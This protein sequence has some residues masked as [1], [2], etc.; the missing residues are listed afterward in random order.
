M[1]KIDMFKN[2]YSVSKTIRFRLIPQGNTL[3]NFEKNY[4]ENDEQRAK[5]YELV[6]EYINRYHQAFIEKVLANLVLDEDDLK[7]YLELSE[8]RN[9]TDDDENRLSAIKTSLRDQIAGSFIAG[10]NREEFDKLFKKELLDELLPNIIDEKEKEVTNHFLRFST[11]FTG[12]NQNRKNIYSNED[13]PSSIAYRCISENLPKFVHNIIAVKKAKEKISNDTLKMV[14]ISDDFNLDSL[15]EIKTFNKVLSQNGIDRYNDV[16]NGYVRD[17]GQKVQGLNEI[18]NLFNQTQERN[19]RVPLLN[20]LYKQILTDSGDVSFIDEFSSDEEVIETLKENKKYISSALIELSD[21]IS[22]FEDYYDELVISTQYIPEIS[23]KLFGEWDYILN[24]YTKK[25]GENS[26]KKST[27]E[28][29]ELAKKE[30]NKPKF[31]SVSYLDSLIN[32]DK[33]ENKIMSLVFNL[34]DETM[35]N[36]N[37]AYIEFDNEFAN[38]TYFSNSDKKIETIKHYLDEVKELERII[39]NI[40]LKHI[41]QLVDSLLYSKLLAVYENISSIDLIYNMVRNYVTRKPYSDKKIKL[42]FDN[43]QL[44]GGWDKNKERDYRS[45]LLR[46]DD[47]YYLAIMDKGNTKCFLSYPN[48]G[49]C[50]EKMEYKLLPGPNK[51]LP[52]VFFAKSNVDYYDPTGKYT[53]VYEKGTF[54]K[55]KDFVDKDLRTI[56]DFY[57]ESINKHGDWSKFNFVFRDTKDYTDIADFYN[58]ISMQGYN[59]SFVKISKDYVDKLVEEGSIYLFQL[60]NKD[61]SKFSKGNPNMH[62]IYFRM[63]FDEDN[64]KD[65]VYKLNGECEMF[66]RKASLKKEKPTHPANVAIKNKN[67]N[68]DKHESKFA[69]DLIKDKRYT[70]N[71][72]FLHMPITMNYKQK[73]TYNSLNSEIKNAIVKSEN[74]YII[75]ID[76]GERNLVYICVIDNEGKIVE[77]ESL[78][79]IVSGNNYSVDYQGLLNEK[80]KERQ[81]ARKDWKTINNIKEIKEG[82]LSQV[83]H[84]ICELVVKYDAI[85]SLENLN[86]GFKNSR[87]KIEKQVYEKF[88]KMLIEK[89]SY[90]VLKNSEKKAS[91]GALRAYQLASN[92]ISTSA[93]Q[94]GIIFH[95]PAWLTSKIDP[96]TG[97][98]NLFS[99]K[100]KSIDETKAFI[101]KLDRIDYNKNEELFE[102]DI[103]YSKF[104]TSVNDFKNKWTLCTYGNRIVTFR[105][106]EKNN[107][108]DNKEVDLT[109][110]FSVLFSKYR[111]DINGNIKDQ[112]LSINEKDFF[113][114]FIH[115]F[116]LMLQMRNSIT[117]NVDVDYIVSPVRNRS[118]EFYDSRVRKE[119]LPLDADANGAYNIA[120]KLMMIVR[121]LKETTNIEKEQLTVSNPEWL[122]FAQTN[123]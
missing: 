82:Y 65:V 91:G 103:D 2:K 89:L 119:G 86:M 39:K 98:A 116:K 31:Y 70:E 60:Y 84:K 104:N 68:N 19:N 63:L 93:I 36:V 52:K 48:D 24:C 30:F 109:K 9:K 107:Q 44:L 27:D 18:I 117:G 87:I 76:R 55:G 1:K 112:T 96:T 13:K 77:Q 54:K 73:S 33:R 120:R 90:L 61:F 101:N 105:N 14:Y 28:I 40:G 53:K 35:N 97:F 46:D 94:N 3:A 102:F 47:K 108:W 32:V 6:K 83:V 118:G 10:D 106:K 79:T 8:K 85:I 21:L 16:V 26:K 5:E 45:V 4:L 7:E 122:E 37:K 42:N 22:H 41:D 115:L 15:E 113:V 78:N 72:F 51:M 64:L 38:S 123:E 25:C 11:Y 59:V 62:T 88:E 95:I 58:D 49:D 43:P 71:Q 67:P 50:Y 69:Y 20:S 114:E 57:K 29:Y 34:L 66:Y 100:Y 121:K 92:Q 99:I 74:N 81:S 80:E 75:G 56:I 17:D 111:I 12:F 110:E 23:T